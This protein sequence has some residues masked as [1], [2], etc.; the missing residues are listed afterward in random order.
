MLSKEVSST[1]FLVF[2]RTRAEIKPR[3]PGLLANTQPITLMDQL[4][5]LTINLDTL[6]RK[7]SVQ[8]RKKLK[9]ENL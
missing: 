7:D 1:I 6:Q 4:V 2:G 3:S 9:V 5:H 8:F